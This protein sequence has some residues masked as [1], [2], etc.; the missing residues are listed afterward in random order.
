M[1]TTKTESVT[2]TCQVCEGTFKMKHGRI[3]FHGY[4]RPGDGHAHGTCGGAHEL[5]YE[6]S[7]DQVLTALDGRKI[8]LARTEQALADLE[9][10]KTT[11]WTNLHYSV[12]SMRLELFQFAIGVTD[13]Y[14]VERERN[15]K[16]YAVKRDVA[17]FKGEVTRLTRRSAEWAPRPV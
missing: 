14:A 8:G 12:V 16:L 17:W 7:R 9:S 2:G 4:K 13:L 6:V 11:A 5:P 15:Q 10:F 1:K 3:V